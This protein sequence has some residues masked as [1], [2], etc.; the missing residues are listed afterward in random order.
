MLG[1]TR[2]E[3]LDHVIVVNERHLWRLLRD[4]VGL[5]LREKPNSG[6]GAADHDRTVPEHHC[7]RLAR[8]RAA[9]AR[10]AGA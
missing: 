4:Y 2:R 10:L 6:G 3:L 1:S 7:E 5:Q 8:G 9:V